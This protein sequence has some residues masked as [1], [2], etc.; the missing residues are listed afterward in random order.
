MGR[1]LT[2]DTEPTDR[3]RDG[4]RPG[5]GPPVDTG[6]DEGRDGSGNVQSRARALHQADRTLGVRKHVNDRLLLLMG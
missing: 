6:A 4:Q 3:G 1:T 2:R 5:P